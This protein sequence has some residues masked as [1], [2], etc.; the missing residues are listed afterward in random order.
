MNGGAIV[1]EGYMNVLVHVSLMIVGK[2]GEAGLTAP[3]LLLVI[4]RVFLHDQA[5]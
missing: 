5:E 3:H 1:S 2:P 4:P